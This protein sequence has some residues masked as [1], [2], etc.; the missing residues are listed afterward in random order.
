MDGAPRRARGNRRPNRV[1]RHEP[2]RPPGGD[3]A[4]DGRE[5]DGEGRGE[6]RASEGELE[7]ES[8]S[9]L[10]AGADGYAGR[11]RKEAQE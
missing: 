10:C 1:H 2:H 8:A 7:G 4:R 5:R 3:D 6:E 11:T 9:G